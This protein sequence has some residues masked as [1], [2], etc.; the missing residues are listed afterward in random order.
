MG[1]AGGDDG[2][3]AVSRKNKPIQNR[4]RERSKDS[5]VFKLFSFFIVVL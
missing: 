2:V 1:T 4:P 3:L 5:I